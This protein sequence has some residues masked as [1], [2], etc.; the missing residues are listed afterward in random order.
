MKTPRMMG[1]GFL[2]LEVTTPSLE[3]RAARTLAPTVWH[4]DFY[5]PSRA[6]ANARRITS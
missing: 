1:L 3:Q 4:R 2:S 5:S 6:R